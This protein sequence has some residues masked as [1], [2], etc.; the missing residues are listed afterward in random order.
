MK[1][2]FIILNKIRG[3]VI[4]EHRSNSSRHIIRYERK[5]GNVILYLFLKMNIIP[6]Q[7]DKKFDAMIQR[8][9]K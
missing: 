3:L 9:E 8:K 7:T 5:E 1:I 2:F 6:V 4:I